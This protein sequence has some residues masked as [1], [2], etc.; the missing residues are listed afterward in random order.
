ARPQID[1][2]RVEACGAVRTTVRIEGRFLGQA[3]GRWEARLCFFAGTALA[4]VR[5][6]L[7]NPRRARHPGGL[8]DLGDPGSIH[9]RELALKLGAATSTHSVTWVAEPGS[10]ASKSSAAL[11]I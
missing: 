4:R 10:P 8:W 1:S 7:H 2:I 9:F 6:T 5:V 11:E 3:P